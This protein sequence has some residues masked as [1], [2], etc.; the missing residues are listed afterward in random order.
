[1]SLY[2]ISDGASPSLKDGFDLPD[3]ACGDFWKQDN[4]E[5]IQRV[6]LEQIIE[7]ECDA[8]DK[9][10]VEGEGVKVHHL[11]RAFSA[12]DVEFSPRGFG[13][14]FVGG[15]KNFLKLAVNR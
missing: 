9:A 15:R 2:T 10:A 7:A 6:E 8:A 11:I 3:D 12:S 5:G 14:S 1:M 13:N 4:R